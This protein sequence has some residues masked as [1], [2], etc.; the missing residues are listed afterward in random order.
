MRAL[1]TLANSLGLIHRATADDLSGG[2]L[3]VQSGE[4]AL[5]P[6]RS[7]VSHDPRSLDAV[8]RAI[9]IIEG[10]IR[11]LSLDVWRGGDKIEPPSI[12][13]NPSLSMSRGSF[14]AETASSLAQRGNAF[15]RIHRAPNGDVF[16][17]EVLNPLEV[18]VYRS[19]KTGRNRY[20]YNGHELRPRAEIIHLR[21]THTPGEVL[22]LGP[23]QAC[24]T[25]VNG[26]IDMSRYAD[27]W[28]SIG[29]TPTGI[30]STDQTLNDEQAAAWKRRANETLTYGNGVAVF[31]QG[32]KFE[33]LL[34]NP[35]EM[36]FLENQAANVTSVARMF[37]IP[38]RLMLAQ[39]GG[40]SMTYANLEQD[41][42]VFL[43]YTLMAY[44]REIEDAFDQ[45]TKRGQTVRFN[46]DGLLRTDTKTRYE[47]HA[48]AINSGFLTVAEVREIEGLERATNGARTPIN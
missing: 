11:Q 35:A 15:W 6:T 23:I 45:L 44:I 38:A 24:N 5:I 4:S 12:V 28:T 10:S 37:G 3:P 14:L 48:I 13:S 41:E 47:A 21:L 33:R 17:A 22:G 40:S 30:L 16:N 25:R 20:D 1:S 43:R 19:P 9:A 32:L 2:S 36:Q 31:G 26:A 46:L 7:A 42:I 39:I 29:G 34:L 18:G 8:Y 27:N